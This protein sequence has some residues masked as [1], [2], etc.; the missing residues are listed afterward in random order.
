MGVL[1]L[2]SCMPMIYQQGSG[3]QSIEAGT[4]AEAYLTVA[5]V[6]VVGDGAWIE[7]TPCSMHSFSIH[8]ICNSK[9]VQQGG[10]MSPYC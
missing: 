3:T 6:E 8:P 5:Q 4:A 1:M 2:T 10:A 7:Q 9:W